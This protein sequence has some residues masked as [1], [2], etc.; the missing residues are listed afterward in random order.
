MSTQTRRLRLHVGGAAPVEVAALF[1]EREWIARPVLTAGLH[2]V[3]VR[4]HQDRLGLWIR[5]MQNGQQPAFL[6]VS[7]GDE[8]AQVRFRVSG[9]PQ[10]RVHASGRERAIPRRQRRV[11]LHQ[12]LVGLAK[13]GP[14]IVVR[15][16]ARPQSRGRE[17]H[18]RG[19]RER[20][21]VFHSILPAGPASPPTLA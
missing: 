17:D 8:H 19:D 13:P 1:D 5:A 7:L 11:G 18:K 15:C 10:S 14:A 12:F 2:Y 21:S 6:G 16:C 4:E 20:S 9:G 3:D